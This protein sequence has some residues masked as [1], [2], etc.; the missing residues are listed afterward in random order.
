MRFINTTFL[1]GAIL[2]SQVISPAMVRGQVTDIPAEIQVLLEKD[3]TTLSD[4]ELEKVFPYITV[5]FSSGPAGV[6][7]E[8]VVNCFDYYRFGS[9]QV[10]AAPTLEQTI[11]GV[12]MTFV[13]SIKNENQY[14]IVDGTVYVKIFKAGEENFQRQ[15]GYPLVAFLKAAD[16]VQ[17]PGN[18]EVPLTFDWLVPQSLSGGEY[19]AAF[20]FVTNDRFNLSGLTFT[21]DVVGNKVAFRV[22]ATNEDQV[23]FD[24]SSVLLNNTPYH[25]TAFP[26]RLTYNEPA[27]FDVEISNPAAI[28]KTVILTW[29]LYNWDGIRTDNLLNTKAES[30]TIAAGENKRLT[31]DSGVNQIGAVTYVVATIQDGDA[32]SIIS[33]RYVRD[34]TEE[35]RLNFPS[36]TNFPLTVGE[37][38]TLF[39]CVHSTNLPLVDDNKLTMTLTDTETGA[40]IHE[41]VYE[42]SVTGAMM[43]VADKFTPTK[44]YGK[45][46]LT[47]TLERY[48][49]VIDSVSQVYDCRTLAP[50]TCPKPEVIP[51]E[52]DD[53][54]STGMI[55]VSLLLVAFGAVAFG[56]RYHMRKRPIIIN[57]NLE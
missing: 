17:I 23:V 7:L 9:V 40:T 43:G 19:E 25:F 11:P 10:D 49:K 48:G 53:T 26:P 13:G 22:T 57:N 14:P 18:G 24:K 8:N 52:T 50:E 28:E 31:Y 51:T 54:R 6:A 36:L 42:G 15:N 47:T 3:I 5:P 30:V 2:V 16:N 55:I 1:L 20:F 37:E 44:S 41:Y 46:T 35:T 12:P 34:N 27:T 33:P 21:D 38:N 29:K 45:V 4:E 39:S 32:T 56:I